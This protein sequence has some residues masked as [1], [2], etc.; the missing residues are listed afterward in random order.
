[1]KAIV[2]DTNILIDN[3]HGFA[4]WVDYLL[5]Q[6]QEYQLV[7][8][9]IV[10]AEYLTA[11][12]TETAQGSSKSKSY[13]ALFESADL[14][15]GIAETLGQIL[16]R[17]T[18]SPGANVGDLIIASTAIYLDAELATRNKADF[19]KIPDLRFFDPAK[20]GLIPKN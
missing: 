9:T 5:N 7:V 11:Q 10:A 8:P 15:F 2:L 17:K 4:P 18:Y 3:V 1:M 12:E 6:A 16:R 14:T 20:R 19:A 13:L